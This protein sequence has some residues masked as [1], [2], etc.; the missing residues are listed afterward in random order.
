MKPAAPVTKTRMFACEGGVMGLEEQCAVRVGGR[1]ATQ[2][3]RF[4]IR[5]LGDLKASLS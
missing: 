1:P 2:K 4:A 5:S 3:S